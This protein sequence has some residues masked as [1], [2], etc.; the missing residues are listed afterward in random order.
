MSYA[1]YACRDEFTADQRTRMYSN[2][3]SSAT[4]APL[5]VSS[6]TAT[7][8][9]SYQSGESF[10]SR[11]SSITCLST[12]DAGASAYVTLNAGDYVQLN[13]GVEI[14]P[15]SSGH[16]MATVNQCNFAL[17]RLPENEEDGDV[18]NIVADADLNIYPNPSNGYINVEFD[19]L[20]ETAVS[21]FITDLSGR[22]VATVMQNETVISG[23]Y[24]LEQDLSHLSSGMYMC[25]LQRG[26]DISTS[27]IALSKN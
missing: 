27:R 1:P 12:Y 22:T 10:W 18:E 11:S 7:L 14:T 5:L 20:E 16:F 25:I 21:L 19:L 15:N 26:E 24:R 2:L 3:A 13:S 9:G 6:A 17:I 4:L 8:G 23:N